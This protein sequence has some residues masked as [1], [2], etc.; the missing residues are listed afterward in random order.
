MTAIKGITTA[1][2]TLNT[3]TL[4]KIASIRADGFTVLMLK[5]TTR[6]PGLP[7]AAI[8]G[9]CFDCTYYD[10]DGNSYIANAYLGV[11]FKRVIDATLFKLRFAGDYKFV[12][13]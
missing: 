12:D 10:Q 11:A 8:R 6:Y 4:D 3:A 2:T 1:I 5:P 13:L 9:F 7:P